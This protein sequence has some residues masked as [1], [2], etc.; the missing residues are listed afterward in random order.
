MRQTLAT[1][2][3][4]ELFLLCEARVAILAAMIVYSESQKTNEGESGDGARTKDGETGASYKSESV[5][6]LCAM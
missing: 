4:P 5:I 6:A 2:D 3:L 1:G